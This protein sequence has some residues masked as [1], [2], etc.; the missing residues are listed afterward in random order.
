MCLL[1]GTTRSLCGRTLHANWDR[2]LGGG[3]KHR[4]ILVREAISQP[5]PYFMFEWRGLPLCPEQRSILP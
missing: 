3:P 5:Q 1:S 4:G 2:W